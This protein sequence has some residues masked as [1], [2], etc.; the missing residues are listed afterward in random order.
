MRILL[1]MRVGLTWRPN[2]HSLYALYPV[3]GEHLKPFEPSV[4]KQGT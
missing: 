2:G 4:P 1:G 3:A